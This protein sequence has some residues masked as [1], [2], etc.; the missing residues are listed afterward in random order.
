M[1]DLTFAGTG[2]LAA[3]LVSVGG[4]NASAQTLK[5]EIEVTE[6]VIAEDPVP[7]GQNLASPRQ[8]FNSLQPPLAGGFKPFPHRQKYHVTEVGTDDQGEGF[9]ANQLSHYASCADGFFDVAGVRVYRMSGSDAYQRVRAD[10]VI[11]SQLG[12]A[13]WNVTFQPNTIGPA[14]I[15]QLTDARKTQFHQQTDLDVGVL[16]PDDRQRLAAGCPMAAGHG[17]QRCRCEN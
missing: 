5:A 11:E 7:F 10:T 3:V 1:E 12:R 9:T 15:H 13:L 17:V 4:Q 14:S 2:L 8:F 6:T 16:L